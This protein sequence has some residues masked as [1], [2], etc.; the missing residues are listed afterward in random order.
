MGHTCNDILFR[1][2]LLPHTPT[3]I[4]CDCIYKHMHGNYILS[5]LA[6]HT[7]SHLA[8]HI[9]SHVAYHIASHLAYY[10]ASHLA[11]HTCSL[12]QACDWNIRGTLHIAG[13]IDASRT[14]HVKPN[15]ML[16]KKYICHWRPMLNVGDFQKAKKLLY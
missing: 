3:V 10:I 8:D 9:A 16:C 14:H 11:Y 5:Y 4:I 12:Y 6:Y 13:S 7:A 15:W 2:Q 1:V